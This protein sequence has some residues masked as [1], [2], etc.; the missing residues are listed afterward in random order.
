MGHSSNNCK[1]KKEGNPLEQV[2][3]LILNS[4]Y[5]KCIQKD[6]GNQVLAKILESD[7]IVFATPIYYF[8]MSAQ[9]KMMIDRFYA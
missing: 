7:L 6:E 1:L 8:G 3:K 9:L 4:G 5:G 2:Y